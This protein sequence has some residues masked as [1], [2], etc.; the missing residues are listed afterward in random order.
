M[1]SLIRAFAILLV[2]LAPVTWAQLGDERSFELTQGLEGAELVR[3]HLNVPLGSF[4]LAG[5]ADG[6]FGGKLT[7]NVENIE[8]VLD[9]Q[10][11]ESQG[12]LELNY[13][14]DTWDNVV[15][16]F[17]SLFNAQGLR[18]DLEATLS[19]TLP[20][21]LT[22]DLGPVRS[23]LDLTSF[24][25]TGVKLNAPSGETV[26]DLRGNYTR[27]FTVVIN[28]GIGD[29]RLQLPEDIGVRVRVEG[30]PFTQVTALNLTREGDSY[31]RGDFFTADV[32]VDVIIS[33]TFGTI[34]LE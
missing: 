3:V 20:L 15:S 31:T 29:L 11:S 12:Q 5:G 34:A 27:S 24:K 26:I 33:Q 22:L 18:F 25:L 10:V 30:G 4:T 16:L 13:Q 19:S 17:E 14:S 8:P 28:K 23:T 21:D 1:K 2:F 7:T 32:F 9:Y 6:L